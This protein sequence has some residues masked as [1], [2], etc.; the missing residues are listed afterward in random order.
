M[1]SVEEK[2]S[3]SIK[4]ID[5]LNPEVGFKKITDTLG[6][7]NS[8]INTWDE[9]TDFKNQGKYCCLGVACITLNMVRNKNNEYQF[10]FSQ[11]NDYRLTEHLGFLA[12][13]GTFKKDGMNTCLN[14]IRGTAKGLIELNDNICK[15][16]DDFKTV[17]EVI[18]KNIDI[19]FIPDVAKALKEHYKSEIPA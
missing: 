8:E 1:I 2:I 5:N 16:D 3:N 10:V 6:V 13:G 7:H 18:L 14:F 11:G 17:R 19:I 9:V 12:S 4:W 15:M